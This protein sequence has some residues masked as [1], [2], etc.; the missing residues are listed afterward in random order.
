MKKTL[1]IIILWAL[2]IGW[3]I[4][5]FS[6]SAEP[7]DVSSQTSGN[8]IRVICNVI[9]PGFKDMDRA[10]Q[11]V[12]IEASQNFARKAAHFTIYTVLGILLSFAVAQ[13]SRRYPV[14]SFTGGVLYAISDEIHQLFVPGRSGQISDV[15]IDSLGVALGCIIVFA[16]YKIMS[17]RRKA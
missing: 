6:M 10:E 5:I 13:H 2:V 16:I 17:T 4:L 11:D 12:I 14:F 15:L 9:Y 3:S 1:T 7:A 8:T